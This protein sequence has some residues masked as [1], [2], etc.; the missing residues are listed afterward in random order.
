LDKVNIE[1]LIGRVETLGKC[2][3]LKG[4]GN[5]RIALTADDKLGRDLVVSWMR[6]LD[7]SIDIDQ[8]GNVIGTRAGRTAGKP[9]LIG[10]HIDTVGTGGL[11][12]G[13]LGVLAGLEVIERLNELEVTTEYPVA[14]G[15]FT[16]EEGVRFTPDMMGSM[17]HQGHLDCLAMLDTVG[18][19]GVKLSD[20][21]VD[22]GYDGDTPC[23]EVRVKAFL[24]LHIEQG[25]V[26]EREG[27]EIGAVTGVQGISWSQFE[28]QGVSNHA[29][30]T[31]MSLRQDAGF[32]AMAIAQY[33]RSLA[34][35]MGGYQVATVG[36]FEIKP[37][38]INVVPHKAKMTVDLRNVDNDLLKQAEAKLAAFVEKIA[39]EENVEISKQQLV[40][41][42]PVGFDNE[43]VSLIE[44]KAKAQG[45]SV[46]RMPSGAGHD[47]QAFAPNCPTGMIFVPSKGGISHN[48][49]EYTAPEQIE[50][51]ANILLSVVLD[52]AS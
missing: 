14:V 11:Y 8:L 18:F 31:P 51:G 39:S 43:L 2:G 28:I 19:D 40:R 48:I 5:S 15:F 3:A 21:L 36:N 50:A 46:K 25:P 6:E 12:D 20:A 9:I 30:T 42:D 7:L 26:L 44:S 10:S 29:G 27:I 41:F 23:G 38:L 37:N 32:A 1:R 13:N 4:G 35:E 45:N 22:I 17:T 52:L 49:K 33:V 34:I 47:A 16:N 24:E